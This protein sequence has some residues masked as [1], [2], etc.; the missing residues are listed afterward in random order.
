MEGLTDGVELDDSNETEGDRADEDSS[1][2]INLPGIGHDFLISMF[3]IL[4]P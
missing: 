4:L 2:G 3:P 1:F